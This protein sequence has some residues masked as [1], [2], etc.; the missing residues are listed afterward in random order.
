MCPASI[1]KI[2]NLQKNTDRYNLYKI[3]HMQAIILAWGYGTRLYP[4]TLNIPKPMISVG[5]KSLIEYIVDK[6]DALSVCD[7]IYIVTNKKFAH[8]FDEWKE[9]SWRKDIIIV[10]DGTTT[11][12]NRLWS[13]GDIQYIVDHY[14]INQDV[15]II[16]GDNFFEDS[17]DEML[18]VFQTQWNTLWLYDT[19]DLE[20]A[21]Q[22]NNLDVDTS[23]KITHFIEK[24]E[25]PTSTISATLIYFFK[26]NILEYLPTIIASWKADRA[27][28]L[29]A[30]ICKM[31]HIYGYTLRGKWFDI[32]SMQQLKEAEA[33]VTQARE[34]SSTFQAEKQASG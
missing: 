21:K 33:W 34:N 29:I 13:L 23:G 12:E 9:S 22:C 14:M 6:L 26:K 24:P 5:G 28:D 30:S 31:E 1:E 18:K 25:N 32:G 17:L 4:L 8:L 3:S 19:Q 16:W 10:N 27:W 7:E 15:I 11:P 20:I 2:I